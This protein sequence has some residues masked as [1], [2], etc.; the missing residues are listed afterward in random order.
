MEKRI[1]HCPLSV[2]HALVEQGKVRATA[3][4][5]SGAAAMDLTLMTC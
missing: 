2:V 4:A 5:L 3:T 1:P